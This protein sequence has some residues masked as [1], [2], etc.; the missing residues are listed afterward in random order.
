MRLLHDG[1][2]Y[3]T[4]LNS[5]YVERKRKPPRSKLH[6]CAARRCHDRKEACPQSPCRLPTEIPHRRI[7]AFDVSV[8][9]RVWRRC[10]AVRQQCSAGRIRRHVCMLFA[11]TAPTHQE[12][13]RRSLIPGSTTA[14]TFTLV[15]NEQMQRRLLCHDFRA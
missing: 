2:R 11:E 13:H 12:S 3:L 5:Q 14:T 15:I 10:S 6:K 4:N 7:M 9:P 8:D 1:D